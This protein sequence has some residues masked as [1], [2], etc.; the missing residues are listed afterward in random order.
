MSPRTRE[1]L[2][3]PRRPAHS[4]T[5]N[6]RHFRYVELSREV[7]ERAVK[8]SPLAVHSLPDN[9]HPN[10][11][12]PGAVLSGDGGRQI[13]RFRVGNYSHRVDRNNQI[14]PS[15]LTIGKRAR[16]VFL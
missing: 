2:A 8:N 3:P 7:P 13:L 4:A 6:R 1:I 5:E 10:A 9:R 12:D 11:I 14:E 16:L 15:Q